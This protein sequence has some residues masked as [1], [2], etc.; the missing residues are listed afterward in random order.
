[1]GCGHS[2][3]DNCVEIFGDG[4]VGYIDKYVIKSCVVCHSEGGITVSIKPRWAGARIICIDG[5]GPR[6]VVPLKTLSLLQDLAGGDCPIR[7]FFD[8]AI[9]TSAG[10]DLRA[11]V[12]ATLRD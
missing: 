6:G 11:T 3:C 10:E 1:M 2:N 12:T 5:G 8:I 7:D 9:G 4:M